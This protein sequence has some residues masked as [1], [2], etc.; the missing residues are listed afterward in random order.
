MRRSKRVHPCAAHVT[1]WNMITALPEAPNRSM[2]VPLQGAGDCPGAAA[3]AAAAPRPDRP[4]PACSRRLFRP[5]PAR[6]HVSSGWR[7]AGRA[8]WSQACQR[9][10]GVAAPGQATGCT[11]GL[12]SP[13]TPHPPPTPAAHQTCCLSPCLP[14]LFSAASSS[15]MVR[16]LISPPASLP[17]LLHMAW[18]LPLLCCTWLGVCTACTQGVQ[19]P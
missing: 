6:R 9:L 19:Q 7:V 16:F 15:S 11:P 12:F 18:V 10:R 8:V 1:E 13:P 4:H 5:L 2:A 14:C 3:V 17:A